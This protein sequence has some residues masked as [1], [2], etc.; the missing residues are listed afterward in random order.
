MQSLVHSLLVFAAAAALLVSCSKS[1]PIVG[2]W[3]ALGGYGRL[4]FSKDDTVLLIVNGKTESGTY[5]LIGDDRIK[6]ELD[7]NWVLAGPMIL[8]FSISGD[9]LTLTNDQGAVSRYRRT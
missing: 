6:L 7:G 4:V 8:H 5:G 1:S 3:T 2:S 9:E